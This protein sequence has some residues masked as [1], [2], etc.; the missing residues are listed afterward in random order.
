MYLSKMWEPVGR[1]MWEH[2]REYYGNKWKNYM[3]IDENII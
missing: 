1:I 3:G 2:L